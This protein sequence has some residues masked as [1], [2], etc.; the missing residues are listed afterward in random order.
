MVTAIWA[1]WSLLIEQE[2]HEH[3]IVW[4]SQEMALPKPTGENGGNDRATGHEEW[5]AVDGHRGRAVRAENATAP[6]F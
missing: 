5:Y 3:H 6:S 4:C 2:G 1:L